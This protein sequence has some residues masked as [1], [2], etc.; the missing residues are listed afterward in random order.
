MFSW[1]RCRRSAHR[2]NGQKKYCNRNTLLDGARSYTRDRLR[3]SRRHLELRFASNQW[4]L[5]YHLFG[6]F[7]LGITALE[8]AEGKPPYGD[9]HPMRAI[10]MIPTKPP[11]SFR[12]PDRWSPEFI[13]FVQK[14]LV[15][16][17]EQR[18]TASSL[19]QHDFILRAPPVSILQQMI[20]EA[21]M[22]LQESSRDVCLPFSRKLRFLY[23]F[24]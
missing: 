8:M 15:K 9:I 1:F 19:L 13:D 3:L 11:P 14:C 23:Q 2:H 17:P 20:Q 7:V 16:N 12:D 4:L 22:I 6:S 21:R 24:S 10:F 18:S 5:S